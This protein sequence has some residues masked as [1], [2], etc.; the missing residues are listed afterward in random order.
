MAGNKVGM[1]IEDV[2][3]LPRVVVPGRC[4]MVTRRCSQR[5]FFMRPD[6]ETSNAFTYCLALA[7]K[8]CGVDIIFTAPAS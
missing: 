8:R 7:A 3:S 5:R 2:T 4:Y 6:R 1:A